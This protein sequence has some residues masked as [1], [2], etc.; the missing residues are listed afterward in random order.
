[1]ESNIKDKLPGVK[2]NVLMSSYTTFKIGGP[3]RYFFTAKSEKDIKNSVKAAQEQK[4]PFFI[5]GAGSNLLVSD[6][7]YG[8]LVIKIQNTG[9]KAGNS[10]ILA[11]SGASLNAA[12]NLSAK[13]MLAGLEWAAGIPGTVGAAVYGNVGAFGSTMAGNIKKVKALD[14][15]N[16]KIKEF[17]AKDCK[18]GNKGSIFKENKN[19]I[20]ISVVL[21]L[22]K[23]EKEEIRKEIKRFV[24][25]RKNNHPLEMPSAGCFFKNHAKKIEDKELLKK[26]PELIEFNKGS[27][28]PTSYLIDKAGV[29]GKI[30]GKAQVSLKHA[31]FIV[32]LGGAKAEDVLALVKLIKEK[33]YEKFRINLEEEVQKL[34]F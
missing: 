16:F 23:G 25:Y 8:G 21:A 12:V 19:L 14:I 1:M 2:E 10:D 9:L 29:K 28:I 3:A 17:S 22:K 7:G 32:N 6:K 11:D 4:L 34:G 33:V 30:I 13:K 18:F 5:L 24:E 20:I 26:F 27:R 15:K 31:N